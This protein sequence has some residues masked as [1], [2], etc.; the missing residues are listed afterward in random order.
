MTESSLISRIDRLRHGA[1]TGMPQ[2][3]AVA[4]WRP[5]TEADIDGIHAVAAAADAVDHPNWGTAREEIA[6]TFDLPHI[7]H[8][9]DSLVAVDAEGTIIAFGSAF[10]HPA[11]VGVLT[12]N[13]AGAVHPDWRRR[14]IGTALFGWQRARGLEAVAEAAAEVGAGD[15][16]VA[17]GAAGGGGAE[18]AGTA[19]TADLK[20]Y[21]EEGNLYAR[22]IAEKAGFTAERWFTS[23]ERDMRLP[24]PEITARDGVT[25]VPY[26]R[27]RDDDAR[28]AHN[29]SFRDHW[30]SQPSQPETWAKFVGGPFFRPDLSRLAISADGAVVGYSLVSVNEDDWVAMGASS[31]YIELIGVV[32]AYR[33]RRIAPAVIAGTLTAIQAAGLERAVLDVDT[34]SPTGAH[35]LYEGL[36]FH[37]TE[38]S[39]ALVERV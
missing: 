34:A 37:P 14:G 19:W 16:A 15:G 25:V 31:G 9:R 12:V 2:H 1:P 4:Q 30:G 33:G 10:L 17:D 38:R 39:V 20:T 13:L 32:R 7:D 5:P 3:E 6:D 18:D 21:A 22:A 24:V 36:G 23:M 11:R 35:T 29:D 8:A 28:L 27:D 26:T